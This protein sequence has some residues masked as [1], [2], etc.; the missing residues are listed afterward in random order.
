MYD[1]LFNSVLVEINDKDAIWGSG[2]DESM[3]GKSYSKGKIVKVAPLTPTDHYPL[4][5][6]GAIEIAN[7]LDSLTGK[8]IL[9]NEG[10]EAGTTFEEDGKMYGLIY[11]WDIRGVISA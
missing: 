3:L 11:W 10:C 1:P 7:K 4:E 8:D 9:W 2:N 6:K 5:T